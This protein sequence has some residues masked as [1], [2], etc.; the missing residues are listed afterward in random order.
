MSLNYKQMS[1]YYALPILFFLLG[2]C[3]QQQTWKAKIAMFAKLGGVVLL[4]FVVCWLPFLS[5]EQAQQVLKRLVPVGRGLF[6]DKVANFWCSVSP[7]W[8]LKQHYSNE[9]L[10]RISMTF[11]L[12]LSLVPC[13]RVMRRPTIDNLLLSMFATAMTFYLFSFQVHEKTILVPLLPAMLLIL[14]VSCAIACCVCLTVPVSALCDLVDTCFNVQHV[15]L[16]Q[17]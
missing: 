3:A 13:I 6:E 10:F 15:P 8:K 14:K 16:A 5:L 2:K 9:T 7:F 1:V 17:A 12:L 4:T 11:T